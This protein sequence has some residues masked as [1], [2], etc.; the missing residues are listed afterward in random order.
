MRK[1][2]CTTIYIR[3][4]AAIV[5]KLLTKDMSDNNQQLKCDPEP[6]GKRSAGSTDTSQGRQSFQDRHKN[7]YFLII[8]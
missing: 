3:H 1:H 7:Y 4:S 8:M 2:A 5:F 6:S